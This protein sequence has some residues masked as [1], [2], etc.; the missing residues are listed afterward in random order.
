MARSDWKDREPAYRALL[1]GLHAFR[2]CLSTEDAVHLGF[3]LP[4]PVRGLYLEGWR[5]SRGPSS[6]RTRK[7]FLERVHEAVGRDPGIDPDLLAH[8][9]FGLLADRLPA[10]EIENVR[11]ATPASLHVYWPDQSNAAA[12]VGVTDL[13]TSTIHRVSHTLRERHTL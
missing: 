5:G 11:A 1:A 9:I 10:I 7:G 3:S 6:S 2:D 4:P 8:A 13:A 12:I